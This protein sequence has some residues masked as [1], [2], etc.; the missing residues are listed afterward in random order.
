MRTAVCGDEAAEHDELGAT[1]VVMD[2]AHEC[3]LCGAPRGPA[4]FTPSSAMHHLPQVFCCFFASN[5]DGPQIDVDTWPR[6]DPQ[7][8]DLG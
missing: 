3:S 2:D 7:A 6:C 8:A 1:A 4:A 5:A